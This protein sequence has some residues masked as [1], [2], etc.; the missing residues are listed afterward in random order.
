MMR[1]VWLGLTQDSG[2]E[3]VDR[4]IGGEEGKETDVEKSHGGLLLTVGRLQ[5]DEEQEEK[6]GRRIEGT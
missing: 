6:D 4:V 3:G 1:Y 5:V 2:S